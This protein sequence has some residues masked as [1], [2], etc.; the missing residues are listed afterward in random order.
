MR[1]QNEW[2]INGNP[3]SYLK[4]IGTRK[5]IGGGGGI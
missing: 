1:N 4:I 5:N 3:S 2:N